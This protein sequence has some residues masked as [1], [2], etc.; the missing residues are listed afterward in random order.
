MFSVVDISLSVLFLWITNIYS[1]MDRSITQSWSKSSSIFS[2][3][4]HNLTSALYRPEKHD[5]GLFSIRST[6]YSS[7]DKIEIGGIVIEPSS[8]TSSLSGMG[9]WVIIILLLADLLRYRSNH[10]R[11]RHYLTSLLIL[12]IAYILFS[13]ILEGLLEDWSSQ[14]RWNDR[15]MSMPHGHEHNLDSS[16]LIIFLFI[17][18][19][20]V[21]Y[22]LP[23]IL[24]YFKLSTAPG[25]ARICISC[26]LWTTVCCHL[27]FLTNYRTRYDYKESFI[28]CNLKL[29]Y[30]QVS[31][32]LVPLLSI[33]SNIPA[34]VGYFLGYVI[35]SII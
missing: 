14:I 19:A 9:F 8:Y 7:I 26:I 22:Y 4:K 3:I 29:E 24:Q 25:H 6:S 20:I 1:G 21:S 17:S 16:M 28:W 31:L 35:A 18:P 12:I 23:S 2:F 13:H 5:Y 32:G 15:M 33:C 10:E 27:S 30:R 11:S 34:L